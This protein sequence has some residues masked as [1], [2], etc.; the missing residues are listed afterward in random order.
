MRASCVPF[1]PGWLEA[2]PGHAP[3]TPRVGVRTGGESSWAQPVG[4]A[5]V[6]GWAAPAPGPAQGA[7]TYRN[8]RVAW[9]AGGA[10]HT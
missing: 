6:H 2:P 1:S 4:L 5:C 10:G 7:Q 9:W 8:P 3:P